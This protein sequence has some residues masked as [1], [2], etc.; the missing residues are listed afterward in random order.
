[1]TFKTS[2]SDC[3][4]SSYAESCSADVEEAASNTRYENQSVKQN[5]GKTVLRGR[6]ERDDDFSSVSSDR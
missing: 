1:M 5:K 3:E 4:L 6:L 2:E